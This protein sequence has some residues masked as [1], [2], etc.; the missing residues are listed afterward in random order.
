MPRCTREDAQVQVHV[1]GHRMSSLEFDAS[2]SDRPCEIAW[3]WRP[4]LP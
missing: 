4:G 3:I 1:V 2:L